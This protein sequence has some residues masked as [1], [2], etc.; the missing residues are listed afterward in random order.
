MR[1]PY[2]NVT[3]VFPWPSNGITIFKTFPYPDD[4]TPSKLADEIAEWIRGLDG[5]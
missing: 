1:T 3:F 5:R 4:M 2:V